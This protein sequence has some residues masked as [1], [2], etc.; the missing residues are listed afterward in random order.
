MQNVYASFHNRNK[1]KNILMRQSLEK[2]ETCVT[3][4]PRLLKQWVCNETN[5]GRRA[6]RTPSRRGEPSKG[7]RFKGGVA[8]FILPDWKTSES[9]QA[10]TVTEKTERKILIIFFEVVDSNSISF[11][12]HII[13]DDYIV[14]EHWRKTQGGHRTTNRKLVHKCTVTKVAE[15]SS[16][17]PPR[18]NCEDIRTTSKEHAQKQPTFSTMA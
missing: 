16:W 5:V 7:P 3:S 4:S 2:G 14:E 13:N 6:L 9:R 11:I 10:W 8:E 17:T 1:D 18:T 12:A 15:L